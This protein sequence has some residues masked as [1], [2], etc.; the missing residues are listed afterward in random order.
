[1]S[2]E[3]QAEQPLRNKSALLVCS[4]LKSPDLTEGL[5]SMG[6]A[7]LPFQAIDIRPLKSS[8]VL[9]SALS[10]IERYDLIIFTSSYAVR[11]FVRRMGELHVPVEKAS[12]PRVC[13]IGPATARAARECGI[14]VSIIPQEF[15]AEGV[16][17]E[18]GHSLGGLQKL[19]GQR[20][21]LPRAKEAREILPSELSAAGAV[22]DVAP[23]YETVQA[24][25]DGS[26]VQ[27][28]RAQPPDL[29]V[30]TSSSNVSNFAAITGADD[31]R[32]ILQSATVAALGPITAKTVESYGKR[33][34]ILPDQNT[35]PSLLAAIRLYYRQNA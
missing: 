19:R 18:L 8:D 12:R 21:L 31:A 9:D 7:V 25:P 30:F 5:E 13:A 11:H 10:S 22:V 24:A 17:R 27:R 26:I 28:I 3:S 20:I 15:V 14:A 4:P 33:P 32:R 2:F 29:L 35:I 23:C 1:M 16:L 34:E 6:A